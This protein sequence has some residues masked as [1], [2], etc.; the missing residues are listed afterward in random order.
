MK[1]EIA[2]CNEF[3]GQVPGHS[4]HQLNMELTALP[5][6]WGSEWMSSTKFKV[7]LSPA[8][9]VHFPSR[10]RKSGQ[11]VEERKD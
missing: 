9:F 2:F 10:P 1:E 7:F 4:Q 8:V 6:A 11:P 5:A 3:H